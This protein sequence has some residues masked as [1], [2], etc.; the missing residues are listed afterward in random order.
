MRKLITG[1][2]PLAPHGDKAIMAPAT[3]NARIEVVVVDDR[4]GSG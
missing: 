1:R 2:I 3:T 4:R